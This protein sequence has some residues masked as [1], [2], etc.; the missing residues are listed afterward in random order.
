L[1]GVLILEASLPILSVLMAP[2]HAPHILTAQT[3]PTHLQTPECMPGYY[4]K[5]S[6]R[7][8][9]RNSVSPGGRLPIPSCTKCEKGFKANA[10]QSECIGACGIECSVQACVVS[11]CR[12]TELVDSSSISRPH[13]TTNTSITSITT[14]TQHDSTST[15]TEPSTWKH[16]GG[17]LHNRR[18]VQAEKKLTVK[19]AG[20]LKVK[21][22]STVVGST[23]ATPTLAGGFVYVPD[24]EGAFLCFTGWGSL[25]FSFL[26]ETFA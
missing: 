10:E 24:W 26:P 17:D 11:L 7:R 20:S 13:P 23:S 6:C 22:E 18:W 2:T 1:L 5:N 14:T 8:C 4:G 19:N 25:I 21:W 3:T 15:R 9:R 12:L 16:W